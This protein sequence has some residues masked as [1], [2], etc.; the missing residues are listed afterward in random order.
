M[1]E[2]MNKNND[3]WNL[4]VW[5]LVGFGGVKLGEFMFPGLGEGVVRAFFMG[6]G[7]MF[8]GLTILGGW[9]MKR[10]EKQRQAAMD[11]FIK[12]QKADQEK[13]AKIDKEIIEQLR[14]EHQ[15]S[16]TEQDQRLRALEAA[17]KHLRGK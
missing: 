11:Q 16:G 14:N 17:L 7:L 8:L 3:W 15:L 1:T 6:A 9:R 13:Q 5:F 4:L 2:N 10:L 12:D